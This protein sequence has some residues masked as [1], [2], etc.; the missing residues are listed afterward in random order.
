MKIST[1]VYKIIPDRSDLAKQ[2]F[3]TYMHNLNKAHSNL[4]ILHYDITIR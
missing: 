2:Y 1:W 4:V 3:L